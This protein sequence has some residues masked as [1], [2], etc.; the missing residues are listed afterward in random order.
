MY[1]CICKMSTDWRNEID[2]TKSDT[3]TRPIDL[4]ARRVDNGGEILSFQ[5]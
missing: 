4:E 5:I 2:N 1:V 3:Q